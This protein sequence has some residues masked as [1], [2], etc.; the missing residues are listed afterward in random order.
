MLRGD[1]LF[2]RESGGSRGVEHLAAEGCT[3]DAGLVW[4]RSG[5]VPAT[6]GRGYRGLYIGWFLQGKELS[7][8]FPLRE[9]II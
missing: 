7:D 6:C 9:R 1:K 5:S 3:L 4:S 2:L 8:Q